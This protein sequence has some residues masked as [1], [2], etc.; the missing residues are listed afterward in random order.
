MDQYKDTAYAAS[1]KS[2]DEGIVEAV[3]KGHTPEQVAR[4]PFRSCLQRL[5]AAGAGQHAALA[6]TCH[7]WTAEDRCCDNG[8]EPF[9]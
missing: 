4:Y 2:F 5:A 7:T 1:L 9:L 3:K 8:L 6:G